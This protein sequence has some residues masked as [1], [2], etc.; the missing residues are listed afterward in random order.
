MRL[1]AF[2]SQGKWVG[3]AEYVED[4]FVCGPG[5]PCQGRHRFA[6]YCQ[7]VYAP[8]NGFSAVKFNV[9]L[10]GRVFRPCPAGR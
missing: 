4:G 1:D 7:K 10:D 2:T 9:D 8:A 3:E 5:K 6:T